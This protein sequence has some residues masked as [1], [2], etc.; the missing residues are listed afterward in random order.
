MY[1]FS[2]TSQE[3]MDLNLD[4]TH[5]ALIFTNITL[6]SLSSQACWNRAL[7]H[8]PHCEI[9]S[10]PT[11]VTSK[12]ADKSAYLCNH[13]R[14][15]A[16]PYVDSLDPEYFVRDQQWLRSDCVSMQS[17]LSFWLISLASRFIFSRRSSYRHRTASLIWVNADH[18]LDSL[19]CFIAY[20]TT[21]ATSL[22]FKLVCM[23]TL[24]QSSSHQS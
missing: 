6:H 1:K 21:A 3:Q 12:R 19:C 4:C 16:M 13:T 5:I 22:S 10:L 2:W 11:S 20:D 7:K 8:G 14:V 15:V 17:D 18:G 24:I 9:I 23:C